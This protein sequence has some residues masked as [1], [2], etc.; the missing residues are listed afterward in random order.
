LIFGFGFLTFACA[1]HFNF[2]ARFAIE[3]LFIM[4]LSSNIPSDYRM[5][6]PVPSPFEK[7]YE[8]MET[9]SLN[10]MVSN[11]LLYQWANKRSDFDD[12]LM[13]D[14]APLSRSDLISSKTAQA[15]TN[16][17]M[18]T[19]TQR[20]KSTK[21]VKTPK[22]VL[23]STPAVRIDIASTGLNE[24]DVVCGRSRM[25]HTHPGNKHFRRLVKEFSFAYQNAKAREDKKRITL[26]IISTIESL[27]GR[28]LKFEG[29]DDEDEPFSDFFEPDTVAAV[30]SSSASLICTLAS[31]EYQYEKVSHALRSSCKSPRQLR[32]RSSTTSTSTMD[33]T[34]TT[35]SA[36]ASIVSWPDER[37]EDY[38]A[39]FAQSHLSSLAMRPVAVPSYIPSLAY[40]ESPVSPFEHRQ[41]LRLQL[42]HYQ[43][44][45]QQECSPLQ[46]SVSQEERAEDYE[47][48]LL[49]CEILEPIADDDEAG[50]QDIDP[51]LLF[52]L[53]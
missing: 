14:M 39:S 42:R 29:N 22:L 26:S 32:R 12:L 4:F 21:K 7:D 52:R 27:G 41:P 47:S 9:Y 10:A 13:D 17:S 36:N 38:A 37:L 18:G 44:E 6:G 19:P 5:Y 28:F 35:G 24:Y 3:H 51:S 53:L 49:D 31:A 2:G 20:Y 45:Q 25:A 30:P 8:R 23:P 11:S 16:A 43:Q 50:L 34:T 1:S 15:P 48:D 33:S 46:H 40:N